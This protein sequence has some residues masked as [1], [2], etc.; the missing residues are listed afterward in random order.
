[1]CTHARTYARRCRLPLLAALAWLS[2]HTLEEEAAPCSSRPLGHQG[3]HDGNGGSQQA[4][5][6]GR[7]GKRHTDIAAARGWKLWVALSESRALPF[8]PLPPSAWALGDRG[9]PSMVEDTPCVYTSQAVRVQ[10][11]LGGGL[12]SGPVRCSL[13][14]RHVSEKEERGGRREETK[15]RP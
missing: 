15:A 2:H 12:E 13:N 11:G 7:R 4:R 6:R 3:C 9:E 1:M 8:F 5:Q 10:W 14:T